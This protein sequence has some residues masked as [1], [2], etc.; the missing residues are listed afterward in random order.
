VTTYLDHLANIG[1]ISCVEML[2]DQELRVW[3]KQPAEACAGNSS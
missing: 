3:L 1:S 2:R